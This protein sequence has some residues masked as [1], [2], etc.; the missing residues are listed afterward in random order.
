MYKLSKIDDRNAGT[1]ANPP[2]TKIS[3]PKKKNY[4]GEE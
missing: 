1:K 3:Q 2:T 4:D